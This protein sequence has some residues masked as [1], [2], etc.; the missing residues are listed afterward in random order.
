MQTHVQQDSTVV[1]VHSKQHRRHRAKHHRVEYNN[2]SKNH[3]Y[4]DAIGCM[5]V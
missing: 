1:R 3:R 2:V 5:V 4:S